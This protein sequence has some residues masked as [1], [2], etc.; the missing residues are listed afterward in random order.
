MKTIIITGAGGSL[1]NFLL[2]KYL[3]EGYK[4]IGITRSKNSRIK[5]KNLFFYKANLSNKLATN[6][7]FKKISRKFQRIN[8]IISC[9]GKSNFKKYEDQWKAGLDD[10]LLSN[11][12]IVNEFLATFKRKASFSKIIIISSIAG[13][14]AIPAPISYSVSKNALIFFV[15]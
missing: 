11:V 8:F 14:K 10:N 5:N 9:V 13:I 12:N 3:N 4:V 2:K 6:K 15:N 1:G 7:L